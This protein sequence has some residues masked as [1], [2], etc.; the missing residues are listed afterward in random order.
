MVG[1]S[2]LVLEGNLVYS[3]VSCCVEPTSKG[4]S[5]NLLTAN[6]VEL[7]ELPDAP[8]E[9]EAAPPPPPPP[10]PPPAVSRYC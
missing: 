5:I 10:P 1:G 3:L 7:T 4:I 2:A 9:E 8:V 6:Y